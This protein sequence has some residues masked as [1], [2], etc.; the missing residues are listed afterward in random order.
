[1]DEQNTQ[2]AA[3]DDVLKLSFSQLL[4]CTYDGD[5]TAAEHLMRRLLP[6]LQAIIRRRVNPQDVEDVLQDTLT[7]LLRAVQKRQCQDLEAFPAFARTIALRHCAGCIKNLVKRRLKGA[8]LPCEDLSVLPS[9]R[10]D[11]EQLCSQEQRV[12]LAAAALSR[13]SPRDREVLRRFYF[14]EQEAEQIC[15]EMNLSATQ[16]RL[17]KS[18]AKQKV[19]EVGRSMQAMRSGGIHHNA[20]ARCA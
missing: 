1:M 19:G 18:R 11:A 7:D 17:T 16:F 13:L 2:K 15:S 20:L 10:P 9:A 4:A 3:D 12:R 8:C 14:E 6:G 5:A